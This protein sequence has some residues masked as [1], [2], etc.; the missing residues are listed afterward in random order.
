MNKSGK[1][2]WAREFPL[3]RSRGCSPDTP[4]KR[5]RV[6]G[7]EP[8]LRYMSAAGKADDRS[9]LVHDVVKSSL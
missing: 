7:L 5:K 9:G 1:D 3:A 4:V 6:D 2:R 8:S